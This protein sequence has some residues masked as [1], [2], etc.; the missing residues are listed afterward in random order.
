MTL[1]HIVAVSRNG[2]IGVKNDLPWKIP[3]DSRFFR[4]KTKGTSAHHGP[5]NI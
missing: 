3:E 1:S 2:V 5:Q 4:D